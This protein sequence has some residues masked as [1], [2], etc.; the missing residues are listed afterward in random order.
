MTFFYR[1]RSSN[2]INSI[3]HNN[4]G[5]SG[6]RHAGIDYSENQDKTISDLNKQVHNFRLASDTLERE[7][8]FYY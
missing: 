3:Y 4:F 7:R 6:S 2:S 8:N 5:S 1:L